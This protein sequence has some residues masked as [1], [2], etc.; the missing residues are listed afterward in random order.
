[1]NNISAAIDDVTARLT[2]LECR[3]G[4]VLSKHTSFRI[5]GPVSAMLLPR[6]PTELAELRAVLTEYGV[7][8]LIIGN[9]TNILADGRGFDAIAVKTSGL[10]D[11]TLT[12]GGVIRAGAGVTLRRLAVF[13]RDSGLGG[14]EFAHGIP[15]TLGGAIVMNAGA[16]GGQMSGVVSSVRAL[17]AGGD[18]GSVAA[19]IEVCAAE[20]GFGY[21]RSRFDG[22]GDVVV[23]AD[24]SLEAGNTGD[25][26]AR[27]RELSERRRASQPLDL[28]S[29]GSAFKRPRDGYAASLIDRAGLRGYS[30][31]GARVSEKHAGF[32][33]ND[34]GATFDDVLELMARVRRH[35]SEA[36][37]IELESE[38]RI[39]RRDADGGARLWKF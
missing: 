7:T 18:D 25:I 27:M 34:A 15:G 2:E 32:I 9:G 11:I 26:S 24:V 28:P 16:Y 4:E 12:N 33:V 29:A 3:R 30:V 10:R 36:F 31:G 13:A 35:V 22:S 39:L 23:S 14:L 38:I 37:G 17:A 6:S 21:R 8:P 20:C 1:M 5:G 19:D